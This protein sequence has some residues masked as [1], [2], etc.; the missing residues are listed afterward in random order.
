[1]LPFQQ[2]CIFLETYTSQFCLKKSRHE[3]RGNIGRMWWATWTQ[4][5]SNPQVALSEWGAEEEKALQQVQPA[6]WAALPFSSAKVTP[7]VFGQ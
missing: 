2:Y 7:S 5:Q 4:A 1:M 3:R 6:L